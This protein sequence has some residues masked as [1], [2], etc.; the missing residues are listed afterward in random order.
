MHH[1]FKAIIFAFILVFWIACLV[2]TMSLRSDETH[3]IKKEF[4]PS[5]TNCFNQPRL[6]P[7]IPVPDTCKDKK[8]CKHTHYDYTKYLNIDVH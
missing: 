5:I 6:Y 1:E 3:L 2:E 8:H 7:G 4:P